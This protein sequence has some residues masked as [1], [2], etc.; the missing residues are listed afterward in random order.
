M[1]HFGVLFKVNCETFTGSSF[2]IVSL[3]CLSFCD[4]ELIIFWFGTLDGIKQVMLR[5]HL[6]L[7][8]IVTED[9]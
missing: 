5:C 6:E 1:N 9:N 8:Q 7:K 3:C 4:G 2:S